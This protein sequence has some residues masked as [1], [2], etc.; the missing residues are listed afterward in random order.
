MPVPVM[1]AIGRRQLEQDWY[2]PVAFTEPPRG[3]WSPG[4]VEGRMF[5]LDARDEVVVSV[6]TSAATDLDVG[7]AF[8]Y[9]LYTADQFERIDEDSYTPPRGPHPTLRV[10][11]VVAD[12]PPR[13]RLP[14]G[15]NEA[16]VGPR[17]A[18][19][20][21]LRLGDSVALSGGGAGGRTGRF[22]VVG[23]ALDPAGISSMGAY[24][25]S[26]ILPLGALERLTGGTFAQAA[27]RFEDSVDKA[28]AVRRLDTRFPYGVMD[29]SLPIPPGPILQLSQLGALPQALAAFLTL[30]G[31]GAL[32]HA[33]VVGVRRRRGDVAILRCL[34]F[35]PRQSATTFL[36]MS[37]TIV[38]AGVAAGVPVGLLIAA[39]IWGRVAGNLQVAADLSVPSWLLLLV[40]AAVAVANLVAA[41][42]ARA[43]V[44]QRPA[45]VLQADR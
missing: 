19:A 8:T 28:N 34:G 41:G 23:V 45:V 14:S 10:V 24:G 13:T 16:T 36:W 26:A 37:T 20:L 2:G 6:A 31:V 43:A 21:H 40:I 33:L 44:R 42:P 35:T 17:L 39:G 32:A 5:D 25:Q 27:V 7:D 15:P 9:A 12:A 11:G 18:S 38:A 1:H 3:I 29:E 4:V 22:Q 30:L